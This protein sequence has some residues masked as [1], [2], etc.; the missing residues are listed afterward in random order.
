MSLPPIVAPLFTSVDTAITGFMLSAA[1]RIAAAAVT[2]FKILVSV[3]IILWGLALWRGLIEEPLSDAVG[4]IF[5]IVL[6][7]VIALGAGVYGPVIASFIYNTPAQ[8]ATALMGSVATPET[9]M[10][11]ALNQGNDIALG[12]MSIPRPPLSMAAFG[13]YLAAIIVWVFTGVIIL[14]GAALILLSKVALGVLVA[15]GPIFIALLLFDT[16]KNF[17]QSWIAQALNYLF[18]YA[19]VAAVVLIMFALWTPQLT[20]AMTNAAG[21]FSA[22]IPMI[23]VGGACFV[24]LMQT[25]GIASGLAGGVQLLTL[26]AMGWAG[27]KLGR[28]GGA[29]RRG[30]LRREE[31][32]RADGSRG[33]EWRG[34]APAAARGTANAYR[35]IRARVAG[36]NS[37]AAK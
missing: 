17:F 35:A 28:A 23:I 16:T 36:G 13:D 4:R 7:G 34:A 26:G 5:R 11:V 33:A 8:L 6:I 9:V 2:P 3:Y 10:D 19:L 29:A 22:L 15:L 37:V 14:Y 24:I 18:I 30:T 25:S 32:R 20:Y 12:F 27:N 1:S 31:Y 21:G